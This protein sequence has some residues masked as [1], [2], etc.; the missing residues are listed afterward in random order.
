MSDR[1]A[2]FHQG[3]IQQIDSPQGLYEHP[4]NTFVANFIGENNRL[5]GTMVSRNGAQC[6]VAL[7][8]GERVNALAIHDAAPGDAVSLSIRPER[9]R[10]NDLSSDSVNRFSGRVQEFIYLGDHV[11]IRLEV[12]GSTGFIVKQ[13][14]SDLSP[15]LAVGDVIPLGWHIEHVRALDPVEYAE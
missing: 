4:K 13:P 9:I 7:Q 5:S 8:N 12:C 10:L 11:R 14:I 2:V 6:E 3:E 1:V 15:S